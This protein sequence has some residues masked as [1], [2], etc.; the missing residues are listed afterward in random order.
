MPEITSQYVRI[1]VASRQATDKIR[2]ITIS[3]SKGIKALYAFNRKVILTFLFA[4]NKGWTMEKAKKW[5][6]DNHNKNKSMLIK[7]NYQ[8]EENRFS[9]AVPILKC[10]EEIVMTEKGEVKERFIE[11]SASSTDVDLHGD[12][13]APSAIKSMAASIKDHVIGLNAEH[14]KSWQSELGDVTKLSVDN[15]NRL[16][17]KA[18]LDITSKANDLW[19]ALTVKK[20]ELGLSIGGFVKDYTLEWDKKKEKFMRIYKDIELD[21]IA[22]TSTPANPKTWVGAI[23]KSISKIEKLNEFGFKD[24]NKEQML[25][26]LTK[27][28]N[29]LGEENLQKI[30]TNFSL[31]IN[32]EDSMKIDKKK[33]SLESEKD[34]KTSTDSE[35][36][37][38]ENKDSSELDNEEEKDDSENQENEDKNDDGSAKNEEESE[39][40]EESKEDKEDSEEDEDE[41]EEEAEEEKEEDKEDNKEEKEDEDTEKKA[42]EG[43]ACVMPDGAKGKMKMTNGKLSCSPEKSKKT[44]S[45]E[46]KSLTR[47][48]VSSIAS[49]A[50]QKGLKEFFSNLFK[51]E[52]KKE[53][54]KEE[55]NESKDTEDKSKKEDAVSLLKII[56]ERQDNIEKILS[57]KALA[58]KTINSVAIN[59]NEEEVENSEET[60]KTMDE[61]LISIRKK[62]SNDPDK[63]FTEC[64]KARQKWAEKESK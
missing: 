59:K 40:S 44:V 7:K 41:S 14:D 20:K 15:K 1:P 42:K 58:R 37:E 60:F 46:E 47:E 17:M 56:L 19:L 11:G 55:K 2:T 13:M 32:K 18:K 61:E 5:I 48:E 62:Y 64:G 25:L 22:V 33:S 39:E 4:I 36:T 26:F 8:L 30:L 35:T 49:D 27:S 43:D 53:K 29:F 52:D 23:A 28:F 45:S 51:K 6:K 50:V 54:K 63:S 21:H 24:M 34:E 3:A 10:Y 9:F 38:E 57:K 12:M 16:L 31:T